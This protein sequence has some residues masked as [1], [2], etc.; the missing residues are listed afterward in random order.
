MS[1]RQ[2]T[3]PTSQVCA[4]GAMPAALLA[5]CCIFPTSLAWRES[6][7]HVRAWLPLIYGAEHDISF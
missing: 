2:L 1:T 5:P 4:V 7:L 3:M 6:M